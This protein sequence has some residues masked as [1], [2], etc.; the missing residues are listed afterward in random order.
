MVNR[1][2]NKGSTYKSNEREL[3]V[4]SLINVV[5]GLTGYDT[6]WFP[7]GIPW[8]MSGFRSPNLPDKPEHSLL[9]VLPS[10]STLLP[11][12]GLLCT[13]LLRVLN[14]SRPPLEF[15]GRTPVK[16]RLNH[17]LSCTFLSTTGERP[18]WLVMSASSTTGGVD[19]YLSSLTVL[20]HRHLGVRVIWRRS[21]VTRLVPTSGLSGPVEVSDVYE[22]GWSPEGSRSIVYFL[23]RVSVPET[24]PYM[25]SS[26]GTNL[27]GIY[28]LGD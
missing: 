22:G 14:M 3:K 17:I 5:R 4:G 1:T 11:P 18:L 2:L 21:R 19:W 12:V 10:P 13:F 28:E 7:S 9:K 16:E 24:S 15:K 6:F 27:W 25:S 8:V 26:L 20:D 23:S